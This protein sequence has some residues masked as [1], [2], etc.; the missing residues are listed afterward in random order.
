LPQPSKKGN[1]I[2]AASKLH[3]S[4]S[5]APEKRLTAIAKGELRGTFGE[6]LTFYPLAE[7]TENRPPEC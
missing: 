4:I 2:T 1:D 5:R 3:R 6:G 7:R